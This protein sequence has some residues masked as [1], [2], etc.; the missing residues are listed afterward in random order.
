ME[1]PVFYMQDHLV[2]TANH[3]FVMRYVQINTSKRLTLNGPTIC[4]LL[5]DTDN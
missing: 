3:V 1:I 4:I 5:I 2:S